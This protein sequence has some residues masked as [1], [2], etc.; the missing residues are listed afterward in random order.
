MRPQTGIMTA[1]N[2]NSLFF[3]R[4]AIHLENPE[5]SDYTAESVAI[6]FTASGDS[7]TEQVERQIPTPAQIRYWRMR[8]VDKMFHGGQ[9]EMTLRFAGTVETREKVSSDLVLPQRSFTEIREDWFT[10]V[11]FLAFIVFVSVRHMFGKYIGTLFQS[12]VNYTTASRMYRE[13][14]ISLGQAELRLEIFTYII[15]GLLFFQ[16]ADIYKLNLPFKG[17]LNFMSAFLLFTLFFFF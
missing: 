1:G 11:V 16:M 6:Q 7:V 9:K 10:M 13:R 17:F 15:L 8:E 5:P 4:E 12:L 14:N 3:S 2:P